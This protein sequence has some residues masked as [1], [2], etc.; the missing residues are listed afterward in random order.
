MQCAVYRNQDDATGEIPY[1]LDIQSNL[2]SDLATR[3][4]VPLVRAGAFGRPASR[5]HP[6][7]LLD[8]E[9]VVM[10]THLLAAIRA[11]SLGEAVAS[12]DD[13]RDAVTSA[14]DVLWSD[15]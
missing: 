9:Q 15:V 3:V 1:L 5:L 8:G 14:I 4:V 13:H 10:A 12:L 2:L 7:F 6:T 11:R